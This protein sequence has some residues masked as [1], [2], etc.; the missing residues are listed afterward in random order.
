MLNLFCFFI[1]V[2]LVT[3]CT[4][5]VLGCESLPVQRNGE[6]LQQE[7]ILQSLHS[8]YIQSHNSISAAS[9]KL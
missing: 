9:T 7:Q 3:K 4:V 2:G 5:S 8:E 1:W 6:Y